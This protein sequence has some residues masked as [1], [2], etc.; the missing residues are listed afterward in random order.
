MF[1]LR[2]FKSRCQYYIKQTRGQRQRERPLK[3]LRRG[4]F[5]EKSLRLCCRSDTYDRRKGREQACAGRD[6]ECSAVMRKCCCVS[7]ESLSPDGLM[8]QPCM[9]RGL[10]CAQ[11]LTSSTTCNLASMVVGL[12]STMLTTIGSFLEDPSSP[13]PRPLHLGSV[14]WLE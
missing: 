8:E 3:R 4:T 7:H 2:S 11:S 12:E 1:H 13:F 14:V 5:V 10:S 9:L 6:S